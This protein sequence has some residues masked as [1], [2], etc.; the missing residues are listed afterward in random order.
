AARFDPADPESAT[1]LTEA[2]WIHQQH[3]VPNHV[4]LER[5]LTSVNENA[6]AAAVKVL[7]EWTVL[8]PKMNGQALTG[9][10]DQAIDRLIQLAQDSSAKVRAQAVIAAVEIGTPRA[11]EIVFA[12]LQFPTDLQLD[13]DISE[14]RKSLDLDGWIRQQLAE[15]KPLSSPA[16]AYALSNA[17][18]DDLLK[19]KKT[20]G[21]YRAI[22][23]RDNVPLDVLRD[24]LTQLAS[25][26]QQP[27]T[28]LL[29]TLIEHLNERANAGSLNSLTRL[30][31]DRPAEEL[32]LVRDRIAAL[33][34]NAV[35]GEARRVA[36]ASLVT[37]DGDMSAAASAVAE[38]PERLRELLLSV[39]L[40]TSGSAREKSF[41]TIAELIP[42][43]DGPKGATQ[44]TQPG[45]SV[46]YFYP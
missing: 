27:P 22:L 12:A 39:P 7:T 28:E 13:F 4:L 43:L 46:E 21:V 33:A 29:F 42:Q 14:A 24:S 36:F 16:E 18:V 38:S 20:E 5:T 34:M 1:P 35:S 15:G 44:L 31:S 45:I 37:A 6:R 11:A 10:V 17:T 26:Q 9:D 41:A 19:M 23:T 2:L 40:I 8:P 32:A 3:R 25:L 30:L